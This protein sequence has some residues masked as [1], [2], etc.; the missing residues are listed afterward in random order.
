M[1]ETAPTLDRPRRWPAAIVAVVVLPVL[2]GTPEIHCAC[3]ASKHLEFA[4]AGIFW[5]VLSCIA[6][7]TLWALR[8]GAKASVWTLWILLTLALPFTP[9]LVRL[10]H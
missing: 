5:F 2:L 9:Y 6:L 7:R 4:S 1:N 10:A 8:Q 3:K